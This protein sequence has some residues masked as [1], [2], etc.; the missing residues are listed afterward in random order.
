MTR[1]GGSRPDHSVPC[2]LG[3]SHEPFV[4]PIDLVDILTL[5]LPIMSGV[6]ACLEE[7]LDCA[8]LFPGPAAVKRRGI[9]PPFRVP[10]VATMHPFNPQRVFFICNGPNKLGNRGFVPPR[11]VF[12]A[13][14]TILFGLAGGSPGNMRDLSAVL[15]PTPQVISAEGS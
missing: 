6:A 3:T 12:D 15:F 13:S 9:I 8:N 5:E 14:A 1:D 10:Q 11:K 2:D 7:I 4:A